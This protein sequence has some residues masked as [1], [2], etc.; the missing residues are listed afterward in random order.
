MTKPTI[1]EIEPGRI[2]IGDFETTYKRWNVELNTRHHYDSISAFVLEEGKGF[3]C[4]GT[5]CGKL[6]IKHGE[7][8][9][10]GHIR[11]LKNFLQLS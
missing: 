9:V 7:K 2:K 8:F 4:T 6:K 11:A 10:C 1:R 5:E 3:S